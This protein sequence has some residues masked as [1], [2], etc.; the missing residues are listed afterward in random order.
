MSGTNQAAAVDSKINAETG[1]MVT[2][3]TGVAK[4]QEALISE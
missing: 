4:V 2:V 1:A 3:G